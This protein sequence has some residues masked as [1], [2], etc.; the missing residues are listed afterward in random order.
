MFN[1]IETRKH[2]ISHNIGRDENDPNQILNKSSLYLYLLTNSFLGNWNAKNVD[3]V[4]NCLQEIKCFE[5]VDY[6]IHF[7]TFNNVWFP[8]LMQ[9]LDM[10]IP[11]PIIIESLNVFQKIS[12]KLILEP[13]QLKELVISL[14]SFIKERYDSVFIEPALSSLYQFSKR[15]GVYSK[16]VKEHL[17]FTDF[18]NFLE[19]YTNKHSAV[20]LLVSFQIIDIAK[21]NLEH[22]F[23]IVMNCDFSEE[24]RLLLFSWILQIAPTFDCNNLQVLSFLYSQ[25]AN[26]RGKNCQL[27]LNCLASMIENTKTL[28]EFD[29]SAVFACINNQFP[30]ISTIALKCI[31]A[32]AKTGIDGVNFLIPNGF[33]QMLLHVFNDGFSL[34]SQKNAIIALASCIINGER[35]DIG[36]FVNKELIEWLVQSMEIDEYDFLEVLFQGFDALIGNYQEPDSITNEFFRIFSESGGWDCVSEMMS[37]DSIPIANLATKF[38]YQ[39]AFDDQI[40]DD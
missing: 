20:M 25:I 5:D 38:Y 18:M 11:P 32:I 15:G 21:R 22:F 36:L 27:A 26:D 2:E 28:F 1:V 13:A 14:Y 12:S 34:N 7:E 40:P 17:Y 3:V 29:Y 31:S 33:G 19:T 4:V 9:S 24:D 6:F 35:K 30:K 16:E 37:N 39:Y 10:T 8:I 23:Y